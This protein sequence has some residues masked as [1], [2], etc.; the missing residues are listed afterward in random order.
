MRESS[1]PKGHMQ[2]SGNPEDSRKFACFFERIRDSAFEQE[3]DA[4]PVVRAATC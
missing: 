2:K 4:V 3:V 1:T